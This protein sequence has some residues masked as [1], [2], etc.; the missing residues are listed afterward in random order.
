MLSQNITMSSNRNDQ[1]EPRRNPDHRN[2]RP[3]EPS[4]DSGANPSVPSSSGRIPTPGSNFPYFNIQAQAPLGHALPH[5]VNTLHTSGNPG[6]GPLVAVGS[7]LPGSSGAS[8]LNVPNSSNQGQQYP[9]Y[10]LPQVTGTSSFAPGSQ[11]APNGSQLNPTANVYNQV[12]SQHPNMLSMNHLN[13]HPVRME[14]LFGTTDPRHIHRY[15]RPPIP[16]SLPLVNQPVS[17]QA[18]QDHGIFNLSAS[19]SGMRLDDVQDFSSSIDPGYGPIG[20]QRPPR[21]IHDTAL[22]HNTVPIAQPVQ[23]A[24]PARQ[25]PYVAPRPSR[26]E[27]GQA[28]SE[29][30]GDHHEFEAYHSN[31]APNRSSAA[32]DWR[33]KDNTPTAG[34]QQRDND[35][36]SNDFRPMSSVRMA[37]TRDAADAQDLREQRMLMGFSPNYEGKV[38]LRYGFPNCS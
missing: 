31:R 11:A 38:E 19:M 27:Q 36:D 18:P 13:M 9:S 7:R 22:P 17:G 25:P 28:G 33:R 29:R 8:C 2:S 16:I 4:N 15:F 3:R 24:V 5:G 20:S 6:H 1:R 21:R 37:S 23:Q 30:L 35:R 12:Y 34:P 14:D 32:P 10:Q 26:S